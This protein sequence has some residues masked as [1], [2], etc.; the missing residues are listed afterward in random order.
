MSLPYV[1][2]LERRYVAPA[3]VETAF[4][5]LVGISYDPYGKGGD[6]GPPITVEDPSEAREFVSLAAAEVIAAMVCG[7]V[8]VLDNAK[9]AYEQRKKAEG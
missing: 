5:Y 4:A 8:R 2:Q 7:Q 3:G 9:E 1:V 6:R